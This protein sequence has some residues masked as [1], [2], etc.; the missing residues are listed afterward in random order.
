MKTVKRITRGRCCGIIIDVQKF[1]LGQVERRLRSSIVANM[2]ELA[3]LLNHLNI[4]V[5]VT[6]EQPVP[7]KGR[8][9]PAIARRLGRHAK[10]FEKNFFDLSKEPRIRRH[11]ARLKRRQVIVTGCETDVC[12][13]QS[14]LG[15]LDLGYEVYVV[16]D[17]LFS[18]TPAIAAAIERMKASGAVFLTFKTLFYE[19]VAS[20]EGSHRVDDAIG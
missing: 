6:L 8:L 15:L 7:D 10:S 9:P 12:V 13:L 11:L 17:L 3:G 14:C 16:E 20:V 18:S 19:L 2:A 4:P 1:F 5:V